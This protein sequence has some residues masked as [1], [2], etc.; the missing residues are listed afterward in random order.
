MRKLISLTL[1]LSLTSSVLFKVT[2]FFKIDLVNPSQEPK[3]HNIDD[4][5]SK[6][7][8]VLDAPHL[9]LVVVNSTLA[10]FNI[11]TGLTVK[12]FQTHFQS[13]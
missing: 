4:K 7:L 13:N 10:V 11:T 8:Q 5:C 9:L 2:D 1:F 3:L 6:F 12:I